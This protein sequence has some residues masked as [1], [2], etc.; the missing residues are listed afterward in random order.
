MQTFTLNKYGKDRPIELVASS[1]TSGHGLAIAM[2]TYEEGYP[3]PWQN[4]TVNLEIATDDNCAFVDTN[5]NGEEII[6]WLISNG[7][8]KPTGRTARSG[9]C[10]YPEVEFD[11]DKLTVA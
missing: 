4:L 7:I 1:Y 9:F 2:I 3:E 11:M 6:E 5:N 10:I 8:G